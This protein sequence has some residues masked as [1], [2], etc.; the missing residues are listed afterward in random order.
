MVLLHTFAR[1][2]KKYAWSLAVAHVNYHLRA[3]DS[4]KDAELVQRTAKE[5]EL[6]FYLLEKTFRKPPSEEA[7]RDIRYDFFESLSRKHKFTSVALAHHQDDQ[8]ETVLLRLIRGTGITGLGGMQ[9]KR[10]IY[11][12]PFLTFSKSELIDFAKGEE[13]PFREDRTNQEL[14]YLRNKVRHELLPLMESYNPQIR[15]LLSQ[16]AETAQ[17]EENDVTPKK[18]SL[19]S[20]K[21]NH[22]V[23]DQKKWLALTPK[24]KA[25]A[26][27]SWF[28]DRGL[29][30]P[31]KSLVLTLI[32]NCDLL[33]KKGFTKE[34]SRLR[35]SLNNG[36]ITLH[37]KEID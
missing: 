17:S 29:R 37:F 36:K 27:R 20:K 26:L 14:M 4:L 5:L 1:I 35:A 7:L 33:S 15:K 34:Y 31:S 30:A 19:L 25:W 16:L 23:F 22:V 10:G 32:Q 6:P 2:Q 11:T 18:I 13:I 3:N 24:E 12:R 21:K 9:M 28:T 8:A